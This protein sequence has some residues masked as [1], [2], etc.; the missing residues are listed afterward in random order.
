[1]KDIVTSQ[2]A[3]Q[4]KALEKLQRGYDKLQ[5]FYGELCEYIPDINF[6]VDEQLGVIDCNSAFAYLLGYK[7]EELIGKS[8]LPLFTKE[9]LI[10]ARKIVHDSNKKENK[11]RNIRYQLI[12]KDGKIVEVNTDIDVVHDGKRRIYKSR[13]FFQ[14]VSETKRLREEVENK[15]YMLDTILN[16]IK[17]GVL[18][19]DPHYKIQFMNKY[20]IKI[21][22]SEVGNDCYKVLHGRKSRCAGNKCPD[23]Q[24]LNKNE[25]FHLFYRKDQRGNLFEITSFPFPNMDKTQ[26]VLQVFRDIT[27]NRRLQEK[28]KECK[29]TYLKELRA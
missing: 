26:S 19:I 23:F 7:Q 15:Q 24:I 28:L 20:L 18:I 4:K 10:M 6:S 8:L 12:R 16:T 14:D 13:V 9:T 1:M 27:E 11:F 3:T 29:L 17:E 25:P 2:L 22:G 5:K 21:F